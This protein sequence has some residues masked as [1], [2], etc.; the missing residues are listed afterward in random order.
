VVICCLLC[1]FFESLPD[2]LEAGTHNAP[3]AAGLAAG[4]RF[5]IKNRLI[6]EES[7]GA[8]FNAAPVLDNTNRLT[9]QAAAELA[10]IQ[11]VRVYFGSP[12]HAGPISFTIEGKDSETV[13]LKLSDRNIAVRGGLHCSPLAHET[14]ETAQSGTVRVAFSHT[15]KP[16][17][18]SALIR[19]VREIAG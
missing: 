13:A 14:A 17:D 3:G 1:A 4:I 15:N 9:H 10:G 12:A 6:K 7:D 16:S 18:L 5:V 19:A 8:G 11:G 2:R